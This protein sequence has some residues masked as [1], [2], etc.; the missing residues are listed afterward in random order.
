[1]A[2]Q[3]LLSI[4][5][6]GKVVAKIV[7]GA[8]GYNIPKLAESLR[9]NP[10][11]GSNELLKRCLEHDLGGCSLI[12]QSSPKMWL[13]DGGDEELPKLYKTKFH[14]P[15]FNPRWKNGTASYVEIVE[16]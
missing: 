14:D 11:T 15:R 16:L 10:T 12:V 8:N 4:T 6:S 13:S 3:G 5:L 2:T 9:K 7:V 1:M